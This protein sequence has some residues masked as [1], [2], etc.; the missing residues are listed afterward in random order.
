MAGLLLDGAADWIKA[1]N[2]D[3]EVWSFVTGLRIKLPV[4]G[5]C[6]FELG[7]G[8]GRENSTVPL[9]F[10]F[11]ALDEVLRLDFLWLQR[12]VLNLNVDGAAVSKPRATVRQL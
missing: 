3:I 10:I 2:S 1:R 4:K 9:Q 12:P 7:D 5:E 6:L 11:D 8:F